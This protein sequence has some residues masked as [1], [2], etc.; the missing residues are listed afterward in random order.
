MVYNAY[1]GTPGLMAESVERRIY[2]WEIWNLVTGQVKL[3]T[4][5]ILKLSLSLP[6]PALY[7]NRIG[8]GLVSSVPV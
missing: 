1:V 2:L 4:N 5:N 8:K 6:R 3:M 7:H